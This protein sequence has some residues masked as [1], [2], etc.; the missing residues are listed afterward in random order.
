M[1][2]FSDYKV[3]APDYTEMKTRYEDLLRR[4]QNTDD[5]EEAISLTLEWDALYSEVKEWYSLTEIRFTQDTTNPDYKA[6]L[7]HRD[8]EWP[9]YI[10]LQTRIK[11][12]I[13]ASPCIDA[14][15]ERF[16]RQV[17]ELWRCD[18]ATFDPSIEKDLEKEA[19][20][21][22][23]YT[24][25][26]G[27]A[28]IE[29][30]GETLTLSDFP[31]YQENPDRA[32]REGATRA[33]SEWLHERAG[34]FDRI[35]GE[36]V[37]LRNRMAEGMG[38]RSYTEVGYLKMHRIGYGPEEVASFREEVLRELVPFALELAD[39]QAETIGVESLMF[40]DRNFRSPKGNPVP[41]GD[42]DWMVERA[43]EM[44]GAMGNG[45]DGFFDEMLEMGLLDLKSRKGKAP[46][47]YCEFFTQLG[48]PF[49]YAN[50][51]GTQH[52]VDVFTHEMGHAFQSWSSRKQPLTDMIWP[53]IEA[54]EIH[55][56]GL[57]FL[58]W[59]YMDLFYGGDRADE[60]RRIHLASSLSF[61]P[62]G[63]AVDHFQHEVYDAPDCSPD[64][65]AEK[66]REMEKTYVPWFQYGDLPQESSGRM[67]QTQSHI[68]GAPFYY[69]D[70]T[71]ALTGALQ[72][73]KLARTD[74]DEAMK[75]YVALCQLGG[76]LS[77]AELLTSV[78]F[79]SP[80]EPGCLKE[81]VSDAREF[82]LR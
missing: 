23:E 20:L 29:F 46:G 16:K 10:N 9:K 4:I 14:L 51:N 32:I 59:P 58:T 17:F 37:S 53:T 50:F 2:A 44:F 64:Q 25:L 62:Y 68:F 11:E 22:S 36:M 66:W 39:Q 56:M 76:S 34:D 7:D 69:I 48:M 41:L 38:F 28:Q 82:L 52:D 19:Q 27:S 5:P 45:L 3:P 1:N 8:S 57:E 73:W 24:A 74:R 33:R 65:R 26:L 31:P 79:A 72:F 54:C 43:R 30:G 6:A 78:G 67:W 18:A 12:A 47:G 15:E 40:W 77:Y 75:R 49:I 70:Y 21:E 63:V 55:S 71:L 61:I 80:F 42:H 35:Y 81:V 60:L 13:L